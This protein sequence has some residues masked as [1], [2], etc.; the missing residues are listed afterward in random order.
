[1][2][3]GSSGV[4]GVA[5][6]DPY[7]EGPWETRPMEN[8]GYELDGHVVT[9]TYN[10]PDALNAINGAMRRDLNEAFARFRDDED[11]W[12]AIVTGAGRAFCVGADLRDGANAAG[13]FAGSFWEKP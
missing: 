9:I 10:R 5:I 1:M 2:G 12:V 8:V 6:L 13:E 7:P 3:S 4:S 11:A